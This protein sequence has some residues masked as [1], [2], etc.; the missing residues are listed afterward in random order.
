MGYQPTLGKLANGSVIAID[1]NGGCSVI[2]GGEPFDLST[3]CKSHDLGYDLLRYAHRHGDPLSTA[4]PSAGRHEVR[5]ESAD[6]VR[7][8]LPRPGESPRATRWR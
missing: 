5:R 4:G 1:P 2:G 8:S 6:P 3:P 7:V